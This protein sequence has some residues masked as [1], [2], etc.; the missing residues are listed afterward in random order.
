MTQD[1]DPKKRKKGN[2]DEPD[3][4]ETGADLDSGVEPDDDYELDV[5]KD[6]NED[7]EGRRS[8]VPETGADVDSGV[9]PADEYPLESGVPA[10]A[11]KGTIDGA[12]KTVDVPETGADVDSGVEPEDEYDLDLEPDGEDEDE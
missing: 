9:E 6:A 2:N 4:P 3:V 8:D 1:P 11:D 12:K 7:E 5:G 10:D